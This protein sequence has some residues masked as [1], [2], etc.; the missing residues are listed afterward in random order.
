MNIII[1][2]LTKNI[3]NFTSVDPSKPLQFKNG[4]FQKI[5]FWAILKSFSYNL[6]LTSCKSTIRMVQVSQRK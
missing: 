2:P 5:N 4:P 6:Q 3:S 1:K